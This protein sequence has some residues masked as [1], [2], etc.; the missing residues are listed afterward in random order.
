MAEAPAVM[1]AAGME[2][3]PDGTITYGN[4]NP[5]VRSLRNNLAVIGAS[6]PMGMALAS[7]WSHAILR[8]MARLA[9]NPASAKSTIGAVAGTMLDAYGVT[10]GLSG[11]SND[12]S[13]AASGEYGPND[14]PGTVMNGMVMLPGTSII[15][16][17]RTV[18][19]LSDFGRTLLQVPNITS[20]STILN[21]IAHPVETY[22]FAG[23]SRNAKGVLPDDL[24]DRSLI[25]LSEAPFH[26]RPSGDINYSIINRAPADNRMAYQSQ[27]DYAGNKVRDRGEFVGL[28]DRTAKSDFSRGHEFGHLVEDSAWNLGYVTDNFPPPGYVYANDPRPE[29]QKGEYFADVVGNALTKDAFTETDKEFV[30]SRY[31]FIQNQSPKFITD[32]NAKRKPSISFNG[33]S[34]EM[35]KGYNIEMRNLRT[36]IADG[37]KKA[38]QIYRA[39]V[40]AQI[41]RLRKLGVDVPDLDI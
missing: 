28:G 21:R 12:I 29:V 30:N 24:Y 32:P 1:T 36:A 2:I 6:A 3:N 34:P 26:N 20:R 5:G 40:N 19:N 8:N 10:S 11:L 15:N 17:M 23:I 31:P 35:K 14:I 39:R 38:E 41:D 7:P 13:R 33:V 37:D 16:D 9:V 22:R 25:D 4:D 27:Y 18:D